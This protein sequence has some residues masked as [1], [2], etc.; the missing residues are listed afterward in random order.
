MIALSIWIWISIWIKA[1][2]HCRLWPPS[3]PLYFTLLYFASIGFNSIH[4]TSL[5]FVYAI[6]VAIGRIFVGGI[7]GALFVC[8]TLYL[9]SPLSV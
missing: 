9:N 6:I 1:L 2:P 5:H 3:S 8:L 4:F 7:F